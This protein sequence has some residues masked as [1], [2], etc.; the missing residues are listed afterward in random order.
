MRF[1][2]FHQKQMFCQE[3]M[4]SPRCVSNTIADC[5]GISI[6]QLMLGIGEVW[7]FSLK[8]GFF[9]RND[10]FIVVGDEHHC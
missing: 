9:S 3:M 4:I 6:D 2:I 10:D 1:G 7:D 8:T 5:C